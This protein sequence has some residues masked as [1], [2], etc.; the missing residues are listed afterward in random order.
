VRVFRAALGDG[1]AWRACRYHD[2]AGE[3]PIAVTQPFAG[4]A[5]AT[6]LAAKSD[7]DLP[8]GAN[9]LFGDDDPVKETDEPL[10]ETA[11]PVK[12]TEGAANRDALFGDEALLKPTADAASGSAPS[13]TAGFKGFVE[14]VMAYTYPQPAHWS[15]MMT[16]FDL[17][18]QG[19]PQQQRQVE[20]GRARRL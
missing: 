14:N 4:R 15:E 1:A 16:R 17:S 3:P 9:A 12:E 7:A 19:R 13:R 2:S 8:T 20:A 11:E 18:A 6:L 10:K 5:S